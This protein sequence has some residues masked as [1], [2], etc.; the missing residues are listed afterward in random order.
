VRRFPLI[1]DKLALRLV[2]SEEKEDGWMRNGASDY[3]YILDPP[4]YTGDGKHYGGTDVF[5]ARAKLLWQ[6]TDNLKALLTYERVNDRSETPLSVNTTPND[7]YFV[8]AL[9]GLPGYTGN[10]PLNN[11]GTSNRDG[12][13]INMPDGHRVDIDGYHLNIDWKTAFGT[14]TWVQGYRKQDSSLPSNYTG[15]VGPLSVSCQSIRHS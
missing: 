3:I 10:D 6:P 1:T 15:V 9:L 7:P 14:L 11:A 4:T 12:Y 2:A 5:T 8:F 13:L